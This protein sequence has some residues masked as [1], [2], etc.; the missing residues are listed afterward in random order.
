MH[1]ETPTGTGFRTSNKL[2]FV[3]NQLHI[4]HHVSSGIITSN[5]TGSPSGSPGSPEMPEKILSDRQCANAKPPAAGETLLSDGNNLYLRVRAAGARDWLLIYRFANNRRKLGLGSYPGVSL[6]LARQRADEARILLQQGIDPKAQRDAE[7]AAAAA[8][9]PE[10]AQPQTVASLYLEWYEKE[11]SKRKDGG[12][13]VN[14]AFAKDVIPKI[15]DMTLTTLRRADITSL[16]DGVAAR[17]VTRTCG[18]LLSDMRQMF[19]FG[20]IREYLVSDPTYGLKKGT[21]KGISPERDRVLSELEIALLAPALRSPDANLM[22]SAQC[23]CWIMLSTLCRIGE[24]GQ[25]KWPMVDLDA[26]Q[27]TIPSDNSK[28]GKAHLIDLSPFALTQFQRLKAMRDELPEDDPRKASPYILPSQNRNSPRGHICLKTYAKQ[29]ADR[30]R[31]D[32]PAMKRR[33]KGDG[34]NALAL[35]GGRWTPH[36]L[37]RTGATLMGSLGIR[38]D[39]IEKC[40]NHTEQNKILRIYQRQELRPEMHAAWLALGQKLTALCTS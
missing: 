19:T 35:P 18:V 3:Q 40:L 24:I 12:T 34:Q 33:I 15:G 27:W 31:G 20:V 9:A 11:A 37:R 10:P 16:L 26:G 22:E 28:N 21:W 7:A 13:M 23:A 32:K 38:P 14:R 29:F 2:N 8:P 4:N 1:Q 36:D 30:Q 6:A 17:G 5:V 39:V 25:A